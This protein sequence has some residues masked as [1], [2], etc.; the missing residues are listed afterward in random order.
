MHDSECMTKSFVVSV[1]K[2]P[3]D[4]KFLSDVRDTEIDT[5]VFKAT[6]SSM[7]V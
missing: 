3:S 2:F 1:P 7:L 6:N 5:F 4:T